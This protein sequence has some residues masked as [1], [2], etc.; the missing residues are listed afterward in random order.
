MLDVGR[1]L[2]D[3]A[4]ILGAIMEVKSGVA[5]TWANA[6]FAGSAMANKPAC[7]VFVCSDTLDGGTV[8][9]VPFQQAYIAGIQALGGEIS[10]KE[11]PNDDHFSLPTSCVSDAQAWMAK[12]FT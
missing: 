2:G 3:M 7:P 6:M 10:V 4:L 9:P 12:Q 11:Y 5:Q 1:S 8:V